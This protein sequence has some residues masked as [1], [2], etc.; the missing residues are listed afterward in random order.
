MGM[1]LV[2]LGPRTPDCKLTVEGHSEAVLFP[3]FARVLDEDLADFF[4]ETFTAGDLV[5]IVYP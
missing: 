1:G 2:R 4:F 3:R 5:F